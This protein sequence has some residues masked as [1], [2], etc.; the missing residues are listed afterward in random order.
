MPNSSLRAPPTLAPEAPRAYGRVG[1]D[2][3]P[4]G[5]LAMVDALIS[6]GTTSRAADRLGVTRT[7]VS[8]AVSRLERRI[9]VP[10]FRLEGGRHYPTAAAEE[11][12]RAYRRAASLLSGV[13]TDIRSDGPPA[14]SVSLPACAAS[15]WL[16]GAI[17]RL[18]GL[19][20]GVR[21]DTHRDTEIPELVRLDA[22]VIMHAPPEVADWDGHALFAER[23]IPVCAPEFARTRGIR[24][25]ADLTADHLIVHSGRAWRAWFAA[26][27]LPAPDLD[28][29]RIADPHLALQSA[30]EGQGVFLACAVIASRA[31][32]DGR[33]VTVGR[34][35]P[36][37]RI[38]RVIWRNAR[39]IADQTFRFVHWLE[40]E[41][42]AARSDHAEILI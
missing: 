4:L 8:Q 26:M 28:G 12:A 32:Q 25:P 6:A 3:P 38:A 10:L 29:S 5:A 18:R 20:P 1:E 34:S 14:L 31:I 24:A 16:S 33:L 17:G 11:L 36:T 13:V 2:L 37:G 40:S 9:G 19:G 27:D 22:A 39:P 30:L 7:A 35:A 42:Q 21:L 15:L 23:V 41:L